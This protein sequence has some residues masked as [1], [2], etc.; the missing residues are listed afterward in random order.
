[1]AGVSTYVEQL[2][3]H[4]RREGYCKYERESSIPSPDLLACTDDMLQAA[5]SKAVEN[6]LLPKAGFCGQIAKNR[7]RMEECV[8]AALQANARLD[9]Q[10]EAQ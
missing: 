7:R 1:M 10:E 3:E 2:C 4:C 8:N 6:G 9:G 5:V